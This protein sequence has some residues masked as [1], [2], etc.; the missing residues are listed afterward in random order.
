MH[1]ARGAQVDPA[2][3]SRPTRGRAARSARRRAPGRR[4]PL[5]P[6]APGVQEHADVG[7]DLV[8][9][10]G[11]LQQDD[12]GED[13]ERQQPRA[14]PTSRAPRPPRDCAASPGPVRGPRRRAP[15][16]VASCPPVPAPLNRADQRGDLCADTCAVDRRGRLLAASGRRRGTP[17]RGQVPA[18]P[19]RVR[20][21]AG[22]PTDRRVGRQPRSRRE[23]HRRRV[24]AYR[25]VAGGRHARGARSRPRTTRPPASTIGTAADRSGPSP[26]GSF[27]PAA[28]SSTPAPISSACAP[29]SR[30][31]ARSRPSST[32]PETGAGTPFSCASGR[33]GGGTCPGCGALGNPPSRQIRHRQPPPPDRC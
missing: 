11:D 24:A 14:D 18:P 16:P 25:P 4:R 2:S 1:R 27:S 20:P 21:G 19:G 9:Q 17:E 29:L 12:P 32:P 23:A 28:V 26:A 31:R 33:S 30:T 6:A 8:A 3:R 7:G 13:Q 10:D 15:R 5:R 22:R